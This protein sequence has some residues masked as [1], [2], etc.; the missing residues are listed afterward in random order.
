MSHTAATTLAAVAFSE[1]KAPREG[2]PVMVVD[3]EI[4]RRP[5]SLLIATVD[6]LA[7][8]H[9]KGETQ[10]LFGKV[11]GVCPRSWLPLRPEYDDGASHPARNQS[12]HR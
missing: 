4:Y 2:L 7:K 5:P 11:N 10:M 6:Q 12:A 8:C 9:R 1:A 3:E